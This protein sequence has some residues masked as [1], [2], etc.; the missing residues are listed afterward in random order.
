MCNQTVCLIAAE[1]ERQGISTV[2]LVLLREVAEAVRPPRALA[3][4]FAHGFPL[5]A[6]ND[7]EGQR[8]VIESALRLLEVE[9]TPPILESY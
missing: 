2:C 4:P 6:V 1:L 5:G 9:R 3:V 8:N 7:A